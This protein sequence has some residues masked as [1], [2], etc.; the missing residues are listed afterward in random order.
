MSELSAKRL[1]YLNSGLSFEGIA[2]RVLDQMQIIRVSIRP[3][4]MPA[5]GEPKDAR[6][7]IFLISAGDEICDLFYNAPDGLRARYWQS[8]DHGFDATRHLIEKLLPSFISFAEQKPPSPVGKVA[9]MASKDIRASLEA[10]S[11]KIWPW[12]RD[13]S[14]TSLLAEHPLMVPRWYEN[15][16]DG[17]WRLTPR[18][19]ELEIKGAILGPDSTEYIPQGKRDR[20]YQIHRVG[21]T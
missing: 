2:S 3:Y 17:M 14:C 15:E 16:P 6:Q 12:E 4:E 8:P 9:P 13:D 20:S 7:I 11:A 1:P 5:P 10:P 19:G 21:F 18:G